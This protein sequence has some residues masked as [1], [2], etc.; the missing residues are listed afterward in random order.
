VRR[1]LF[2]LAVDPAEEADL[3]D[4]QPDLARQLEANLRAWQRSVLESLTGADYGNPG[5]PGRTTAAE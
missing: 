2:D 3:F 1:E 4:R 5:T